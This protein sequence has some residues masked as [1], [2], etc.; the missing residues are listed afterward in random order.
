[1]VH[2][3]TAKAA[4]GWAGPSIVEWRSST[5]ASGDGML[6]FGF[7]TQVSAPG[8]SCYTVFRISPTH[9][10]GCDVCSFGA[11]I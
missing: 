1:M 10:Q 3:G 2:V 9:Y 5:R 7:G 8:A 6:C 4:D 11:K